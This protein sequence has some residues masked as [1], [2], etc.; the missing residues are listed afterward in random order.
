MK[1]L[2]IS[3]I[4]QYSSNFHF[5]LIPIL[6]CLLGFNSFI[7]FIFLAIYLI[8]IYFKTK[9]IFPILLIILLFIIRYLL[10]LYFVNLPI[11]EDANLYILNKNDNSYEGYMY[12]S[13]NPCQAS[14]QL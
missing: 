3:K 13:D 7:F 1:S 9:L 4:K 14:R 11:N 12:I 2:I 5:F 8:F 10:F 6:L